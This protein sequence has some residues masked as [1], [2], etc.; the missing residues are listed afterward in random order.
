MTHLL[1]VSG[2]FEL[3]KIAVGIDRTQKDWFELVHSSI[4][5]QQGWVIVRDYTTGGHVCV[6]LCLEELNESCP[7]SVACMRASACFVHTATASCNCQATN[8][9]MQARKENAQDCCSLGIICF[10]LADPV[11]IA[12]GQ[13]DGCGYKCHGICPAFVLSQSSR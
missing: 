7:H 1:S 13:H 4:G 10:V 2:T 5:K 3:G 9:D 8:A 12:Q 11:S 6:T